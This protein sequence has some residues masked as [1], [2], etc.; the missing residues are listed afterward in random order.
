MTLQPRERKMLMLLPVGVVVFL[1]LYF[2]GSDDTPKVVAPSLSTAAT[3]E[4]R[5][6]H[7]RE[8]AAT[9]PA[10]EEI[11]KKV[12]AELADREKSLI[13]A[14]TAAQAQAQIVQILRRLAAQEAPP[15]DIRATELG[16]ITALGDSYGAANVSVQMECR[17]DQL[18][19]Y[20]ASVGS[21]NELISTS[22]IRINST[23]PKEKTVNVRL[24]VAGVV[25]RK[26]V[27]ERKGGVSF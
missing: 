10:K 24:T 27:P 17:M 13:R 4:K 22:E 1:A 16:G 19:N 6:A 23:S 5:L 20:L 9:V 7:L 2:W 26:L 25:P 3:A 8:V 18:V 21:T 15:I 14:D 12:S 11:F